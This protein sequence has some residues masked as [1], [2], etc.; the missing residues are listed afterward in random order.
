MDRIWTINGTAVTDLAHVEI[1]QL[2]KDAHPSLKM[3]IEPTSFGNR[4][5]PR[6]AK[7]ESS[8]TSP[9][10]VSTPLTERTTTSLLSTVGATPVMASPVVE[11]Q[12]GLLLPGYSNTFNRIPN[13]AT[14]LVVT[15]KKDIGVPLGK[16]SCSN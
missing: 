5:R 4:P 2:I 9:F 14:R 15:L 10:L 13:G 8:E 6:V 3:M 7:R 16:N 1:V 12:A 11:A